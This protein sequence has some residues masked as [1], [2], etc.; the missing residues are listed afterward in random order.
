MKNNIASMIR[1]E[2]GNE[3]NRFRW[4]IAP[5]GADP[6]CNPG[7]PLKPKLLL[8]LGIALAFATA[9]AAVAKTQSGIASFYSTESGTETASG[10][11]LN[12]GAFT[13]AHRSLPFGSKVRVTNH[14][15]WRSI[16][17][18]IND[19]GPFVRGRIIDLTPAG[20][21]AL[22]FS[23]LAP[24]TVE[25]DAT[26][27]RRSAGIRPRVSR[28]RMAHAAPSL[29]P[30]HERTKSAKGRCMPDEPMLFCGIRLAFAGK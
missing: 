7:V 13:A 14:K 20:A 15:N 12:P 19:R 2:W 21:R 11:R 3:K 23:G 25:S 9:V 27:V 29:P 26:G 17:V 10:Q 1:V 5:D 8:L 24:V 18:T 6:S 30:R 16:W 4:P 22:G 28:V